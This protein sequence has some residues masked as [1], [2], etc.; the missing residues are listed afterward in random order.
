VAGVDD[1][2]AIGRA[3]KK[4]DLK[5]SEI[6]RAAV[7]YWLNW[8]QYPYL[9]VAWLTCLITI[10]VKRIEERSGRKWIADPE[11]GAAV[12]EEVGRLIESF[13]PVAKERPVI[14]PELRQ[15]TQDLVV[16]IAHLYR[17]P[18]FAPVHAG[19]DWGVL[20]LIAKKLGP[21]LQRNVGKA[22]VTITEIKRKQDD[23]GTPPPAIRE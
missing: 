17:E 15:I 18:H 4:F 19:D 2:E 8:T 7:Q 21:A 23:E 10:L 11:T 1:W 12:R 22:V 6:I 20:A 9:H 16:V 5:R 13:I 3:G 14:S